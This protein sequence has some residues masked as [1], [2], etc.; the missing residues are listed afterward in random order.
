MR[1]DGGYVDIVDE[2]G[3]GDDISQSEDGVDQRRFAASRPAANADLL[4]VTH[5]QVDTSH[6][7]LQTWMVRDG[8]VLQADVAL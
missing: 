5:D 2:H 6:H 3:S 8:H 1:L 4:S 7:R